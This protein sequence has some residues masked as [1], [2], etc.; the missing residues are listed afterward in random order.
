MV[1]QHRSWC[2]KACDE[3]SAFFV[4]RQGVRPLHAICATRAQPC[5]CGVDKH[6]GDLGI[7]AA[8][9]EAEVPGCIVVL[10]LKE[11][12]YLRTDPADGTIA[13]IGDEESRVAEG[14]ERIVARRNAILFLKQQGR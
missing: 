12:V 6:C 4:D 7:I 14:E 10:L 9:E 11:A 13:T 3:K 2:V 1:H 5:G 8:I